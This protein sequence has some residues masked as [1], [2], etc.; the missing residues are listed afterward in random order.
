MLDITSKIIRALSHPREN[1][2]TRKCISEM[3]SPPSLR[4][5]VVNPMIIF[6]LLFVVV[7]LDA[8]TEIPFLLSILQLIVASR[9]FVFRM[10]CYRAWKQRESNNNN[11]AKI[12]I[13]DYV[14]GIKKFQRGR[15]NFVATYF[16]LK[17]AT[18]LITKKTSKINVHK[19][20]NFKKNT[21][22]STLL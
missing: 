14:A 10:A 4:S 9:V 1:Y 16:I 8:E 21:V 6:A 13:T 7:T 11:T 19:Y 22:L 20:T 17:L 5:A 12:K 2:L 15:R 18:A 3:K